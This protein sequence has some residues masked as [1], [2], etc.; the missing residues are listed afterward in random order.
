MNVFSS[1]TKV[2]SISLYDR[3]L[4]EAEGGVK[5]G[6]KVGRGAPAPPL[7]SMLR[8]LVVGGPFS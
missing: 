8:G 7:I 4:N 3:F 2:A 1:S 6:S 5:G